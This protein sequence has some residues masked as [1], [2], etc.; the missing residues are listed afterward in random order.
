MALLVGVSGAASDSSAPLGLY[1]GT[2]TVELLIFSKTA[3]ISAKFD[4]DGTFAF[5]VSG[6]VSVLPCSRNAL[7]VG[8]RG[9]L[10]IDETMPRTACLEALLD[11]HGVELDGMTIKGNNPILGELQIETFARHDPA[12]GEIY[13]SARS[14]P[15]LGSIDVRLSRDACKK[16]KK[17]K[18]REL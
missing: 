15:I 14:V 13:I 6:D 5:K 1:C 7:A 17:E 4:A 12:N 16:K 18:K 3:R 10:A 2:K 8:S 9:E 11:E